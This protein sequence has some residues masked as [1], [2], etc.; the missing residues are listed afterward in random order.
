MNNYRIDLKELSRRE[1][2][3]VEWKKNGDDKDIARGIVRTLSAFANDIS[4]LGGGYVVCGANEIKDSYGFASVEY[5]GL[6]ANKLALI[7]GK[8][9][10]MCNDYVSPSIQPIVEEINHPTDDDKRIL[11]FIMPASPKAHAYRDDEKT[12]YWIR[13]AKSTIEAR[14]GLFQKLM[15]KKHEIEYFDRRINTVADETDIDLLIIR[16]YMA[17][18]NLSGNKP[19]QDYISDREQLTALV[20]PLCAKLPLDSTLRPLNFALLMFGKNPQRFFP[21]AYTIVS[22]YN[23]KER[24]DVIAERYELTGSII[25][26]AQQAIKLL[27]NQIYV[28]F[29]KNDKHPNQVKYPIRALQEA[30]INAIVHRDYEIPQPIRITVFSDRIEL[31]SPGG[32]HWSVSQEEFLAGKSSSIWRNQSF[33]H[34]FYKLQ[35]AQNEGQGILTIMRTMKLEG[36]PAPIFK[37]GEDSITCILPAH[38]RH[39]RIRNGEK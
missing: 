17:E 4:N 31:R 19:L 25:E 23:G 32:L 10:S 16:N 36:C 38:E 37:I 1:S 18:M 5:T 9:L 20:P 7:K 27:N 11:V 2:E 3:Q 33:A 13:N 21:H 39:E 24:D 34:L 6:S 15:I 30:V 35:L 26:Q 14:N 8:I 22:I 28:A 12:S 29:D